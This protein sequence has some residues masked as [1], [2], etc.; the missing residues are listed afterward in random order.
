MNDLQLA[1]DYKILALTSTTTATTLGEL[2]RARLA[3]L[4]K[5]LPERPIIRIALTCSANTELR[6]GQMGDALTLA[7][8]V[9]YV[10]DLLNPLDNLTVKNSATVT[11][12]LFFGR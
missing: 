4:G 9:R 10:F 2:V 6:D 8:T 5:T 3:T 11:I 12:E 1:H 7:S